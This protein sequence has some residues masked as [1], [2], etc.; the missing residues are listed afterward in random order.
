MQLSAPPRERP[1][2]REG[3]TAA[4]RASM[5]RARGRAAAHAQPFGATIARMA[6]TTKTARAL[7]RARRYHRGIPN[8]AAPPGAS[9]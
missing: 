4:A 2:A 3:E 8:L 5:R 1:L 7:R 9:R 6:P